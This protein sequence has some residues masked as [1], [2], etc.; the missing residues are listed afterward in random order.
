MLMKQKPHEKKFEAVIPLELWTAF[1][2][3][4]KGRTRMTN[5]QIAEALFRL[6]LGAPESMKILAFVANWDQL[7]RI[8]P[9]AWR[10]MLE[11]A[12]SRQ[13]PTSPAETSLKRS[14]TWSPP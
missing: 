2:A 12:P 13:L 1:E 11:A 7:D 5:P 4:A 8:S 3:W 9:D 10:E 6:F 14:A